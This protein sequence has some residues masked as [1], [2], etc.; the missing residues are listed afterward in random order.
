MKEGS[1]KRLE[2]REVDERLVIKQRKV[3][4]SSGSSCGAAAAFN[5]LLP[6]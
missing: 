6:R 4:G 3:S 5:E 1:S 2:K